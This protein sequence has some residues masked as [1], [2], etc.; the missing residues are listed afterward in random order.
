M[1][2]LNIFNTI[3][4]YSISI[5]AILVCFIWFF[6]Y[7]AYKKRVNKSLHYKLLSIRVPKEINLDSKVEDQRKIAEIISASEQIIAS[8]AQYKNPIVFEIASP[9]GSNEIHF[10]VSCLK[11]EQEF[12]KK[13]ITAFYPF[14]EVEE[15]DDYSIFAPKNYTAASYLHLEK[16]YSL[17]LKTYQHF[18]N[19]PLNAIVNA[20]SHIDQG[21]GAAMQVIIKP[22]GGYAKKKIMKDLQDARKGKS[23]ND[24]FGKIAIVD[25][26]LLLKTIN[27]ETEEEK[28]FKEIKPVDETLVKNLEFKVSSPLFET[29]I[30]LLVSS[31]DKYHANFV[32]SHLESGFSEI[33]MPSMNGFKIKRVSSWGLT[34][35]I[36]KYVY[37]IFDVK[38]AIVLNTSEINTIWHLPHSKLEVPNIKWLL[39]RGSSSPADLPSEG[40]VLGLSKF[41]GEV[42]KVMIKNKDR[43]LHM[44]IIGQTGTGK[45]TFLKNMM[46]QDIQQGKGL[47]FL[48]P[49]G[50]EAEDLLNYIPKERIQDVI[51]FNPADRDMVMGLN[52]L[53]YTAN[54]SKGPTMIANEL[55]EIFDKLYDLKQT[56]GPI[57][58]QYMRNALNLLMSDPDQQYTLADVPRVLTD[59]LFRRYLLGRTND[60]LTK[61][62]WEQEA[63]KAGGDLSL[64]N[65]APYIN[66]K[67]TPFLT[68]DFVR[69]IIGQVKTTINFREIMDKNKIFIVNLSKGYMD[70]FSSYFIGMIIIGKFLLAAFSR[71]E[72]SEAERV[73]FNLYADEFQNF[74]TKNIPTILSEARK[75]HLILTLAHQ[76]IA[77]LEEKIRESAFGNVGTL[78][79]F[80]VSA[81]DAE[82]LA[83]Y[84]VPV[85]SASDLMNIANYNAYIKLMIDGHPARPFNIQTIK[86][87]APE[88]SYKTEIK[89]LSRQRYCRPRLEVENEIQSRYRIAREDE[90]EDED[91]NTEDND[92]FLSF[93]DTNN[94]L[95]VNNDDNNDKSDK[96]KS[97]SDDRIERKDN[98]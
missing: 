73:D 20:F 64:A 63:E 2:S 8:L 78:V 75:Y 60:L 85:F 92:D 4:I 61:D 47:C 94:S 79:S 36:F 37:R 82:Y 40:T 74:T 27:P 71:A 95:D 53:E 80:R 52:M 22:A 43:R 34:N 72:L 3:L 56:G 66:S 77:Q 54:D 28:K 67:L 11:K 50:D 38:N 89:T 42:K 17:P 83:K 10:Y 19:D 57:F 58:E 59:P 32:L 14:A 68:N 21:E 5:L 70:E 87:E 51:Y 93:L 46:I 41:R 48:D 45:T 35:F 44:Y 15:V 25:T 12:V 16:S 90:D 91:S 39:S 13:I 69:P 96:D 97:Q 81:Q 55:I 26:N 31:H 86:P 33:N 65:M 29:N 76:Y 62:F 7:I 98:N 88:Q 24:L 49:H 30:R 23:Y 18:E 1:Q 6:N 9:I 84:M